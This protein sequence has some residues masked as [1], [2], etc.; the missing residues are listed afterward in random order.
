MSEFKD[1]FKRLETESNLNRRDFMRQSLLAGLAMGP[2]SALMQPVLAQA[3]DVEIT[4]Y[5]SDPNDVARQLQKMRA[6]SLATTADNLGNAAMGFGGVFVGAGLAAELAPP[7]AVLLVLDGMQ[8]VIIGA[9][10]YF[11]AHLLRMIAADPPRY[12]YDIEEVLEDSFLVDGVLDEVKAEVDKTLLIN[13]DES[14]RSLRAVWD[15]LEWWQAAKEEEDGKWMQL[16]SDRFW[17][18]VEGFAES[19]QT[20]SVNLEASLKNANAAVN[21]PNNQNIFAATAQVA[22]KKL[23]DYPAIMELISKTINWDSKLFGNGVREA[24]RQRLQDTVLQP[25]SQAK[26]RAL[27][28]DLDK[29]A[30]YF[31]SI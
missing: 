16:H 11:L 31:A 26:F 4:V 14:V 21:L 19:L 18:N 30:K 3:A 15:H 8:F 5:G 13:T 17:L 23:T 12:P 29:D 1:L 10:F 20:L 9:E 7:I 6:Q 24:V 25:V 22:G 2:L 28:D 27:L